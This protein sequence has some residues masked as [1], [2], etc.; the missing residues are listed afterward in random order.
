MQISC[1]RYLYTLL[2]I[3]LLESF[4]SFEKKYS[5]VEVP[6]SKNKPFEWLFSSVLV[7]HRRGP[8]SFPDLVFLKKILSKNLFLGP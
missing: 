2:T 4:R 6:N 8:G 7:S 1:L 5:F 3:F